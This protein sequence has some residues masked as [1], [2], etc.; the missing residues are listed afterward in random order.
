MRASRWQLFLILFLVAICAPAW[1]EPGHKAPEASV[2]TSKFGTLDDG[3]AVEML[4]LKNSK[5]AIAKVITYGATLTELWVP[6]RKGKMADVVLGFDNLNGYVGNHPWFGSTVG[7]VANRI[8]KGKFT[9]DGKEYSLEVNNPPNNLH[10]GQK[11]I[12]RVV[13]KAE[14]LHE[15][16]AAAARF[17]YVSPD[18]DAGFPGNVSITVV[19]RLTDNNELQIDY[20]AATDKPTPVNLTNHSYFNLGHEKDVLGYIV[21]LPADSYTPVDSNLIPTGEIAPVKGTPLD[22]TKPAP[23]GEHIAGMK[24]DPGG[25]DH[26]FILRGGA[27]KKLAARVFD[28]QSGRQMEVW[29]TEPGV[30]FYSGN[31]LD[32]TLTGKE[33]VVYGKHSGFCLETQ[34]YP[35]SVNHPNFPS[36]ILRP[37]ETYRT[38]TIYQFSTK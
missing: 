20:S 22:F 24:G 14:P 8:A 38:Q 15:A 16:Q 23:I 27:G 32:G 11:G 6:D 28:P 26:N 2:E 3:T 10:S 25:Y 37:G 4:T 34:H 30:Q 7:R 36:I 19:Y 29:T 13:W 17:T 1:S 21:Y 33:G 5:G 9:L 18:G 12:S 35:D 31:F